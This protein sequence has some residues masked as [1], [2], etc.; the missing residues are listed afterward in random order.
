MLDEVMDYGLPQILEPDVLK[1]YITT[2]KVNK[3]LTNVEKL[4]QITI[5]ATGAIPWRSE[6]IK[7]SK[8][9]MF[10]DI[11]EN[12]NVLVS[13]KGAILKTDVVG[14]VVMKTKLSGMPE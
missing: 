10:I 2:G 6:G 7:Y 9:E 12:L 8:N 13:N 14:Q 11:I 4:S 1:L 3:A 5:Q